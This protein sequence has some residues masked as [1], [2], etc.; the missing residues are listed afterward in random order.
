MTRKRQKII[1]TFLSPPD[2]KRDG[3]AT[4]SLSLLQK[5]LAKT[6]MGHISIYTLWKILHEADYTFQKD[7]TWIKTGIVNRKRKGVV[8]EIE[9]PDAEAKKKS[10]CSSVWNSGK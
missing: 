5:K 10:N 7:R 4:W 9:D 8:V 3:T 6:E 2:R 1:N